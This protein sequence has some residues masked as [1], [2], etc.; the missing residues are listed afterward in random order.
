MQTSHSNGS[1][2]FSHHDACPTAGPAMDSQSIRMSI[3]IVSYVTHGHQEMVQNNH[4]HNKT[5]MN[6]VG[7]ASPLEQAQHIRE[8]MRE[9]QDLQRR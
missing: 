2:E 8:D 9:V 7:S 5:T 1:S 4:P 3:P 6:Y